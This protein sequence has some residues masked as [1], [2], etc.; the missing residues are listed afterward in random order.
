VNLNQS[1][2]PR[3]DY[4]TIHFLRKHCH[5]NC[6][7][8]CATM[9]SDRTNERALNFSARWCAA[10]KYKNCCHITDGSH[11]EMFLTKNNCLANY[12]GMK[13]I[14]YNDCKFNIP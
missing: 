2:D 8:S 14:I 6:V 12:G 4:S 3:A 11:I 1:I 10:H 9:F 13:V 7:L 5:W